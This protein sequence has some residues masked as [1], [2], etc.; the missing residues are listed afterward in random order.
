MS[1]GDNDTCRGI[2]DVDERILGAGII[3]NLALVAIYAKP[4]VPLP[5]EDKFNLMIAQSEILT[6]IA[7]SNTDFFGYFR[8]IVSSFEK[9]DVMFFPLPMQGGKNRLLVI[10]VT[11]PCDHE[12]IEGEVMRQLKG[13]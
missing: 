3:E 5:K 7:K 4:N 6:S 12:K 10:Q 11:R 8:Y 2:V 1:A 9:S 13:G